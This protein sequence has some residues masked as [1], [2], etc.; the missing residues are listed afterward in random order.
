[1]VAIAAILRN[2]EG[3][4]LWGLLGPL[5]HLTEEQAIMAAIQAAC[6]FAQEKEMELTQIETTNPDIFDL[7]SS[8]EHLIIPE[9]LLEAF[10]LFNSIHFIQGSTSRKITWIPDHMN[11]VAIY[12]AE[13]G[14]DNL[15]E[16]VELP[17]ASTFENLQFLL[18][19]DM[20][21]V[22]NNPDVEVVENMG[23]G[24]VVDGPP[25]SVPAKRKW[26]GFNHAK[27][28][29]GYWDVYDSP[30]PSAYDKKCV[31]ERFDYFD[32]SGGARSGASGFDGPAV[33]VGPW[34]E[35]GGHPALCHC[36]N[37]SRASG[38]SA[39]QWPLPLKPSM[40]KSDIKGKSKMYEEYAFW[41]DGVLSN[42]A[43]EILN[44]GELTDYSN[45]FNERLLDLEA[46][47]RNGFLVKDVLHHACLGSLKLISF[48]MKDPPTPTPSVPLSPLVFANQASHTAIISPALAELMPSES[49][50]SRYPL[51][52]YLYAA[53]AEFMPVD[54]VVMDMGLTSQPEQVPHASR[55]FA[56]QDGA[57]S[58]KRIRR[59]ASL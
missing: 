1:M 25:P 51:D 41:N 52:G 31:I 11:S 13:H 21:M 58:V 35:I 8:Q 46:P 57:P 22:I 44:S 39:V 40:S 55:A 19:R 27:M 4:K 49:I 6:V 32:W 54:Q 37:S 59:A 33:G 3:A 23:L 12:M 48:M 24:E 56:T 5:N 2:D 38:S 29:N 7:I 47:I 18:D 45:L 30:S 34:T 15:S 36:D 17:G 10:R 26:E 50:V 14:L 9:D 28:E 53:P 43:V 42:R 20:G 16:L